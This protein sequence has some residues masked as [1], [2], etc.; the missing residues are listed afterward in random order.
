[1]HNNDNFVCAN[2]YFS[3]EFPRHERLWFKASTGTSTAQLEKAGP[4]AAGLSS[5]LPQKDSKRPFTALTAM[6]G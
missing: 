6:M 3:S 1:M 4:M 2:F 5:E